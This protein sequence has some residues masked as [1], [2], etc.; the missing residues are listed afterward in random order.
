MNLIQRIVAVLSATV[1]KK[2]NLSNEDADEVMRVSTGALMAL[3]INDEAKP[4]LVTH[5]VEAL[6]ACLYSE[7]RSTKQNAITAINNACGAPNGLT[8]F[9]EEIL[10]DTALVLEVFGPRAAPVLNDKL[11]SS[12]LDAQ[13]SALSATE[14]LTESKD[15]V[16]SVIQCLNMIEN[17]ISLL[18]NQPDQVRRILQNITEASDTGNQR[19][20][21]AFKSLN[22]SSEGIVRAKHVE[23][24]TDHLRTVSLT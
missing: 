7:N 16:R 6:S 10:S 21:R 8:R 12:H 5:A 24:T 22:I 14:R 3:S 17:L 19:V 11:K 2:L 13:A 9:T 15:G 23:S 4:G 20:S 1:N 18:E